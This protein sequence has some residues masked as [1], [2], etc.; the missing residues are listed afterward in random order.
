LGAGNGRN[1]ALVK[2]LVKCGNKLR[3]S[4]SSTTQSLGARRYG[5]GLRE[6]FFRVREAKARAD[7]RYLI[8]ALHD[9]DYPSTAAG[10]LAD[11]GA[12]EAI[13]PLLRLLDAADPHVRAAAAE[14]LGR[15]GGSEALPRLREI[16]DDDE[17]FVRCW[18][19]GA[20]GRIGDPKDVDLLIPLLADPSMRVS[21]AT[22]LA[23]GRSVTRKQP[24]R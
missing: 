15:L 3:A 4:R 8:D 22:A 11:L 18:A 13:P 2:Y 5:Q 17:D 21:A 24:S 7:T 12:H 1:P 6:R 9:P 19:I 20:I 16:A 23:L 10:Y 14:A